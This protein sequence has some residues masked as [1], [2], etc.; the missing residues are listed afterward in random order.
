MRAPIKLKGNSSNTG[1]G[2]QQDQNSSTGHKPC[3]RIGVYDIRGLR[4]S[5]EDVYQ[6]KENLN[7]IILSETWIRLW[8]VNLLNMVDDYFLGLVNHSS[9]RGFG[10]ASSAINVP[11]TYEQG[12]KL[13][14]NTIKSITI[15]LEDITETLAY[16]YHQKLKVGKRYS[17][18]I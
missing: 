8:Y 6:T 9:N 7:V 3:L 4:T 12:S 11:I 14:Y 10:G 5:L 13:A 16:I 1:Q 17:C 15:G 18:W 2:G